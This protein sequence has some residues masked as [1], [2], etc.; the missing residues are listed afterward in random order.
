MIQFKLIEEKRVMVRSSIKK[1]W[2]NPMEGMK[3]KYKIKRVMSVGPGTVAVLRV[4]GLFLTSSVFAMTN[5]RAAVQG[6][7]DR[8]R[9]T[10][11]EFMRDPDLTWLHQNIDH[12]RG[13]LIFSQVLKGGFIFGGSGG[14][15]VLLVRDDRTGGWSQPAFYTIGSATFGFQIGGEAAEVVVLAMNQKAVDT[16]LSSS[17]K[18]GG[19]ASVAVGPMG[20]GAKANTSI[21][22]VTADFVAFMKTRGLYGGLNFEGSVIAVRNDLNDV[23]YG[24]PVSPADIIERHGVSNPKSA[25]LREALKCKC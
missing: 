11:S 20:I 5:D 18:V 10:F 9:V 22:A 25:E 15:G 14:T 23:Y 4:A 21:P 19:D 2:I 24:K 6:L 16:L 8:S 7:V 17:F 1:D 13:V 12:A 3:M